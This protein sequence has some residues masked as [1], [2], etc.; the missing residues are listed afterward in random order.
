M[1][2][3]KCY[4]AFYGD[5]ISWDILSS[6][7]SSGESVF[8]GA[9]Q[10]NYE[11]IITV[12]AFGSV[13]VLGKTK[14]SNE[15][16]LDKYGQVYWYN[17]KDYGFG[18]APTSK[19]TLS[20]KAYCDVEDLANET[21]SQRLCWVVG[22]DA[23]GFRAGCFNNLEADETIWKKVVYTRPW[24]TPPDSVSALRQGVFTAEREI[25]L[26]N[27]GYV[28][29][30]NQSYSDS[31][32]LSNMSLSGSGLLASFPECKDASHVFVGATH[33]NAGNSSL[34]LDPVILGAYA[35][36]DVLTRWTSNL[37]EAVWDDYGGV[38]WY[39]VVDHGFG[40]SPS[41]NINLSEEKYCDVFDEADGTCSE[42]LCWNVGAS[43]GGY[44][45]G[46]DVELDSSD[47]WRKVIYM[48]RRKGKAPLRGGTIR[49]AEIGSRPSL[50]LGLKLG[51]HVLVYR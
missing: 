23:G 17:V 3:V 1:E 11:S 37:T 27:Q 21:C 29:C 44:R 45:A 8:V 49:I 16:F 24:L 47:R 2:F 41:A 22:S 39:N 38:Y 15:A 19:I 13:R 32:P 7:C 51:F 18:F 12:G 20:Q 42:R 6:N 43:D 28:K 25:I 26:L 31:I 36:V 34:D 9:L 35:S 10:S 40:F 14:S 5:S 46:C 50:G 30:Y 33:V 48:L 4:E